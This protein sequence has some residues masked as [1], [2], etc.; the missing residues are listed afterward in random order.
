MRAC[1]CVCEKTQ[2]LNFYFPSTIFFLLKLIYYRIKKITGDEK[3]FKT[4]SCSIKI[5]LKTVAD[6]GFSRGGALTP[7]NAI[8]FQFFAKNCMKMKEFGPPAPPLDPP[9]K[10]VIK[11]T[12]FPN[13][14]CVFVTLLG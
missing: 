5:N 12:F 8:I 4:F 11:N 3:I 1:V 7:K 9:M 14:F 2:P 6:P 13:V 10:N